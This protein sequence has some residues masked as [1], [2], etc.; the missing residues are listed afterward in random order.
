MEIK[1]LGATLLS[2]EEYKSNNDL[3]KYSGGDWWL[4]TP[5]TYYTYD[6]DNYCGNVLIVLS[7]G[8]ID[9]ANTSCPEFEV[10]PSLILQNKTL[11]IGS[12]LTYAGQTFTV[13]RNGLALCDKRVCQMAFRKDWE[14]P[15][16]NDYDASDVKKWVD[17]WFSKNG[18]IAETTE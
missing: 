15:Y 13:L 4:R 16:A 10:V 11:P 7:S 17:S 8:G 1:I 14:S 9:I 5:E 3:I 18:D 6:S 2:E 12:K